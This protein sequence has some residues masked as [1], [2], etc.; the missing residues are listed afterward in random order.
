MHNDLYV[1]SPYIK[2]IQEVLKFSPPPS[3]ETKTKADKESGKLFLILLIA[4]K[5]SI[6]LQLN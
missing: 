5:M 2:Q 6:L 1:L 3:R 4:T